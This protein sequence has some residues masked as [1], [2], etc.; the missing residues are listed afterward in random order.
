MGYD[1]WREITL[2][3]STNGEE[4][5]LNE[6]NVGSEGEASQVLRGLRGETK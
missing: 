1:I 6:S 3:W 2:L 4:R 5:L